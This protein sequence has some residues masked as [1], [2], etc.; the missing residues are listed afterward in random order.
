MRQRFIFFLQDSEILDILCGRW[1]KKDSDPT[2]QTVFTGDIQRWPSPN[3][4]GAP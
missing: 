2:L 1:T 4:R 3:N